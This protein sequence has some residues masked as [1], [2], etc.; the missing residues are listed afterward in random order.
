MEGSQTSLNGQPGQDV[1]SNSITGQEKS[2]NIQQVSAK[3]GIETSP[4]EAQAFEKPI[5]TPTSSSEQTHVLDRA[6]HVDLK[7]KDVKKDVTI[8]P[9]NTKGLHTVFIHKLYNM[10]EDDDLKHLIWWSSTNESFV[11]T[12][13][14]EFSKALAQYFKHTNVASFVRQL[15]MYGFHKVSDGN[16]TENSEVTTWEFRHSSGSFRKGDI[17]SLKSIKRRSSKHTQKGAG[18]NTDLS[19]NEGLI[20]ERSNSLTD[21]P[22]DPSVDPVLNVRLAEL[23]H[24]LAALRHEHA[25]LQLRYDTAIEDLRKTNLDMV[26]LLDLVQKVVRTSTGEGDQSKDNQTT[27]SQ[28]QQHPTASPLPQ[29]ITQRKLEEENLQSPG[30]GPKEHAGSYTAS[31]IEGDIARFRASIIQRAA[32]RDIDQ[33][34]VSFAPSYQMSSKISQPPPVSH[35]QSQSQS[36]SQMNAAGSSANTP[37][38]YPYPYPYPYP[39]QPQNFHPQ[40]HSHPQQFFTNAHPGQVNSSQIMQDPFHTDRKASSTSSRSRNMSILY[41]PLAP[42]AAGHVISPA[43]Q[44]SINRSSMSGPTSVP[45][46]NI[47]SPTV[48]QGSYFP[49]YGSMQRSHSPHQ[50]TRDQRP[51]SFPGIAPNIQNAIRG[52]SLMRKRHSSNDATEYSKQ[53]EFSFN[54]PPR[55]VPTSRPDEEYQS[56]R[57]P[58][59]SHSSTNVQAIN[60]N[61]SQENL[62]IYQQEAMMN[63]QNFGKYPPQPVPMSIQQQQQQQQQ[64]GSGVYALLNPSENARRESVAG[65]PPIKKTRNA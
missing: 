28:S 42:P 20:S 58:K 32:S 14:E 8:L 62:Q 1:D 22:M 7:Q 60:P 59:R 31:E 11:I 25:R 13:G 3:E 40:H 16:T 37:E 19:D 52:E 43:S 53:Q 27:T 47:T 57:E 4:V 2:Q 48:G 54:N 61:R 12:P 51:G 9:T 34:S 24:N 35:H 56:S 6:K 33:H 49:D 39:Q 36:Q 41:D 15:N 10:L 23:G 18:T 63:P 50:L 30:S 46:T 21:A 17:D 26:Y 44:A 5:I 29:Q 65:R 55:S 64:P 38:A 45:D